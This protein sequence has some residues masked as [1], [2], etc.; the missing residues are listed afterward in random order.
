MTIEDPVESEVPGIN[1]VAINPKTG[2]TFAGV[3]RSALRQDPDVIMVWE[4]RDF[5]TLNTGMEA[6]MTWHLVFSTVHTNSA[7]ETIT[8]VM[9]MGAVSYMITGTFNVI[10]AQRLGRKIRDDCKME[11]DVKTKYPD[12]FESARQSIL[13]MK[14]DALER[15]M[16][17]RGITSERLEWFIASGMWY[18]ADPDKGMDG[19]KWRVGIYEMLE[20]DEEIKSMLLDGERALAVEK[21]ALENKGMVNLE[22]DAVFKMIQGKMSIEEVYRLVKHKKYK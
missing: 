15:E 18:I 20:F 13:T 14:P 1:Q 9:N 11:L 22:R 19:Y 17:M 7:A 3:L 10:I 2:V 4:I 12:R 5:E 6:A 8:R 21:Y 16:T